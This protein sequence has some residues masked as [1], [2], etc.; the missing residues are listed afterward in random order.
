MV[1]QQGDGPT[2]GML[3]MAEFRAGNLAAA[4]AAVER[5]NALTLPGSRAPGLRLEMSI[6]AASRDWARVAST[7]RALQRV[8]EAP[9]LRDRMLFAQASYGLDRPQVGRRVLV[10]LLEEDVYP[11]RAAVLFASQHGEEEPEAAMRYLEKALERR[12]RSTMLI[13]A[14]TGLDV[15]AGRT[16]QAIER[17]DGV[18]QGGQAGPGMLYLRGWTLSQAGEY[19]RAEQDAR[20]AFEMAPGMTRALE[21]LL[22]TYQAQDK[23]D[24]AVKSFEEAEKAGLLETPSRVLLARLYIAQGNKPEAE[25]LLE[26]ILDE[27]PDLPGAKNDLAYLIADRG[28]DLERALSLAQDAQQALGEDPDTADT[29][30]FIYHRKGLDEAALQQAR[31]A[32]ELSEAR[33]EKPRPVYLYHLGLILKSLDRSEEAATAFEKA[34]AVQGDFPDAERARKELEAARA[35]R[36][37]ASPS[38]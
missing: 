25:A 4:A 1:E 10:S 22:A 11:P 33:G 8:G 19:E 34:L 27:Q 9:S 31:Y 32:I 23:L 12:P 7:A 21:L 15:S 13:G 35:A 38:S 5:A 2:Y 20:R 29:L 18:I 36:G 26:K 28:G 14:I 37:S 17:L 3:A 16:Q 6:H 24:E 30:S